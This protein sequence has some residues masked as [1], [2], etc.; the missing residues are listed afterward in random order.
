M[1]KTSNERTDRTPSSAIKIGG[2]I[3]ALAIVSTAALTWLF[4]TKP[5]LFT[6]QWIFPPGHP[7]IFLGQWLL[8]SILIS[9]IGSA[10]MFAATREPWWIACLLVPAAS[11]ALLILVA[12]GMSGTPH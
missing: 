6:Q 2:V 1:T 4:F 11:A 7:G 10:C 12:A 8:G 5:W 3:V 9:G